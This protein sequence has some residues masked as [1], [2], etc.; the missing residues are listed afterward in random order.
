M[1]CHDI[2]CLD[3][4]LCDAQQLLQW[5]LEVI[6]DVSTSFLEQ[7]RQLI[8][9]VRQMETALQRRSKLRTTT[10]G[11]AASASGMALTD[12]E[13]IS[14]QIRLDVEGECDDHNRNCY[15]CPYHPSLLSSLLTITITTRHPSHSILSCRHS[16]WSG[17]HAVAGSVQQ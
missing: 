6:E 1:T 9:T 7:L 10:G 2:T 3:S 14:L 11:V 4:I 15:D 12:S 17:D 8:E 13:K 16:L 5:K